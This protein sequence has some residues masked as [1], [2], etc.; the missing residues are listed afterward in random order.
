M[1][2][3]VSAAAR[4]CSSIAWCRPSARRR[5]PAR[6]PSRA[7]GATRRSRRSNY[8]INGQTF[9]ARCRA[10]LETHAETPRGV[11]P[12]AVASLFGIGAGIAGAIIY[13]AV[14]K[15]LHLEI[16]IVAILIGYMVGYSVRRGVKG[17]GGL[18][19]QILAAAL[20]YAS[21]AFAY[22]PIAVQGA[23]EAD[24]EKQ[25]AQTTAGNAA[26][27]AP[28]QPTTEP[29]QPSAAP[30]QAAEPIRPAA[31]ISAGRL[32]MVLAILLGI[33]LSL[34]VMI[35]FASLPSGLISGF[36]IFIGMRQAWRMTGGL[37]LTVLG[38]Y[39]VGASPA[40]TPA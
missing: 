21:V 5:N 25:Q 38:P 14:M 3:P 22:A 40:P 23:I 17:R 24:R 19:Y 12:F 1:T 10:T 32:V 35:V 18:R 4:I 27:T 28:I 26:P 31:P 29:L 8:D 7:R 36:I 37:T 16:G 6:W 20:T 15:I 30:R 2:R 39:R 9:C 11:A 34:P 33:T 13:F